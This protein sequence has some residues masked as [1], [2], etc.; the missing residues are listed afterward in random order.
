M[1]G[2]KAVYVLPA[3]DSKVL[4]P[5]MGGAPGGKVSQQLNVSKGDRLAIATMYGFS[6]DWFFASKD[7]G[8]DATKSGDISTSIGLYDDGSAINQFPGA[9]ITQF[10]LAGTPLAE[11]IPIAAVPNPNAFTTLP[12]IDHI[13][14][15]TI[16]Q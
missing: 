15:V 11:S 13:I 16:T 7:N 14:K 8:V 12:S 4:L 2:V 6:N 5:A 9:G 10:N 1:D 3:P